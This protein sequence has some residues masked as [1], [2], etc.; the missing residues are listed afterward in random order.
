MNL[1]DPP[2]LPPAAAAAEAVSAAISNFKS[3][4]CRRPLRVVGK[5]ENSSGPGWLRTS[6]L[7]SQTQIALLSECY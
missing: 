3:R 4:S 1:L 5:A 6:E 7:S 2:S